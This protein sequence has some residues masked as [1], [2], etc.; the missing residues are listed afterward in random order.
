MSRPSDM[1]AGTPAEEMTDDR[2]R[3]DTIRTTVSGLAVFALAFVTGPILARAL[4]SS[5]RGSVAAVII[6]TQI[7]GWVLMFGIPQATAYFARIRKRR[8]L[9]MSAWVFMLVVGLP[10]VLVVWPLVPR[11]LSRH[12]PVV[13]DFFR[14]FLL[15]SLLVL[16]FTTIIDHL[17]GIGRNGAFNIF[18]L[19]Q[20][21]LNTVLLA[22]LFVTNRL[23]LRTALLVTL[24]ANLTAWLVTIGVNRAWPGRGFRRS[25]FREQVHYGARVWI[26]TT[27]AMVIARFDQLLMVGLVAPRALGLYVVA[28]TAAQITG[29]IGQGVALSLLP[30]LR[31]DA[32]A[33]DR[34]RVMT[35]NALRWTLIASGGTAIVVG[36]AAPVVLPFVYGSE[37][38]AAV[39]PLLILLPGQVCQDM[40]N[41]L[42]SKLEADDRPGAASKGTA[43]GAVTTLLLIVP[44]VEVHGIRGAALVTSVSQAVFLAYVWFADRHPHAGRR[45][46]GSTRRRAIVGWCVLAFVAALAVVGWW[47]LS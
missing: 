32:D 6:P 36:L 28:S 34:H 8:Q 3:R 7:F 24:I 9:I 26:G 21:V 5:G 40:A 23:D 38:S 17:R 27:S 33:T 37:F 1:L 29:P 44:A 16:P 11:L 25:V 41:V 10:I 47:Q 22:A 20:Y 19:L 39:I 31:V 42:S 45:D 13:V 2:L 43:L 14:A 35:R 30:H 15:A 18:R 4:G 46:A 12:P